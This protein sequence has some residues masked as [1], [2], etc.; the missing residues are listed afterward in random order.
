M[1]RNLRDIFPILPSSAV[2]NL[3]QKSELGI[4]HDTKYVTITESEAYK[5]CGLK[6]MHRA[7]K[8]NISVVI[9]SP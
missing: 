8:L 3:R 4:P 6:P 7:A 1:K 9:L 5:A 2:K